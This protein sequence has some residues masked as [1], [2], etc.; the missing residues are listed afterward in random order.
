MRTLSQYFTQNELENVWWTINNDSVLICVAKRLT[1]VCA[2]IKK[3]KVILLRKVFS[4]VRHLYA[5]MSQ[6]LVATIPNTNI[7]EI[8]PKEEHAGV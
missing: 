6:A 5:N 2:K 4:N 7:V 1:E 8:F 3:A